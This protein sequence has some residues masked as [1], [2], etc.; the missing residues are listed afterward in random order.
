MHS[1]SICITESDYLRLKNLIKTLGEEARSLELELDVANIVS[2][3]DVT[4]DLVTMNSKVT[5]HNLDDDKEQTIEIVYPGD[6]DIRVSKISILAP[7][8][9]ALIGLR[10]G[11]CIN[12]LF[13]NGKTKTLKVVRILYQPEANGDWHL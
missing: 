11:Q 2:N 4:G 1:D 8:A 5:Y 10:I 9:T 13:P 6:A 12:W 7:I 3:E